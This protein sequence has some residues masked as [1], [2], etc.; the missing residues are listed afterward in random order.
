MRPAILATLLL[1]PALALAAPQTCDDARAIAFDAQGQALFEGKSLKDD[2]G[3]FALL[4]ADLQAG[5]VLDFY[6]SPPYTASLHFEWGKDCS[7]FPDPHS[8]NAW[9]HHPRY[10][11]TVRESGHYYFQIAPWN[12]PFED[13][14]QIRIEKH[15]PKCGDG[16]AEGL[17]LW[18]DG[19]TCALKTDESLGKSCN[20]PLVMRGDRLTLSF[21]SFSAQY[22]NNFHR[23]NNCVT[24]Y[25]NDD[26][27]E[28]WLDLPLEY[29]DSVSFWGMGT[30]DS[31]H[32]VEN[33]EVSDCMKS[34]YLHD[35][36]LDS[37]RFVSNMTGIGH[38]ILESKAKHSSLFE[39]ERRK[40][41]CG[42]G[43]VTGFEQC[44]TANAAS[45][46]GCDAECM[47]EPNAGES[48]ESAIPIKGDLTI[49]GDQSESKRA[50]W[51]AAELKKG[52]TL[53]I[54]TPYEISYYLPELRDGC[55]DGSKKLAFHRKIAEDEHRHL[56]M[57]IAAEDMT[58]YLNRRDDN[59]FKM[60]F[61]RHEP[62]CGDGLLEGIEECEDG[63][64]LSGDGCF[65]CKTEPGWFCARTQKG[66]ICQPATDGDGLTH[67]TAFI[68]SRDPLILE[69]EDFDADFKGRRTAGSRPNAYIEIALDRGEG[70]ELTLEGGLQAELYDIQSA[71][72]L[73][74]A[75]NKVE[76]YGSLIEGANRMR[77]RAHKA[78]SVRLRIW[79]NRKEPFYG[80][81]VERLAADPEFE[82]REARIA[83][84]FAE[85]GPEH[86]TLTFQGEDFAADFVSFEDSP[87]LLT[88]DVPNAHFEVPLKKGER[89]SARIDCKEEACPSPII[90]APQC[91][92]LEAVG[93]DTEHLPRGQ[94]HV[95]SAD[96]TVH[97]EF[98]YPIE[99][100]NRWQ[101]V[102]NDGS[103]DAELLSTPMMH[104]KYAIEIHRDR[105]PKGRPEEGQSP[106]KPIQVQ[107]D[108]NGEFTFSGQ[109]FASDFETPKKTPIRLDHQSPWMP[110]AWFEIELD[111]G[112]KLTAESN[113]GYSAL[114]QQR[115]PKKMHWIDDSY[116]PCDCRDPLGCFC[117][118]GEKEAL[119]YKAKK[120]EKLY[121]VISPKALCSW[122]GCSNDLFD[123][124]GTLKGKTIYDLKTLKEYAS[125]MCE[126]ERESFIAQYERCDQAS[127]QIQNQGPYRIRMKKT[128]E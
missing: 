56:S 55:G 86:R 53:A 46:L 31:V 36:P 87:C 30:Y 12:A 127:C 52:E 111:Q 64:Q 102:I 14:Y 28:F 18:D 48:C 50:S 113:L 120:K 75:A 105:A 44:E 77:Y 81:K 110:S 101:F 121:F 23:Q 93:Y 35:K 83:A 89:L 122:K 115:S 51:Y 90:S 61:H 47:L 71:K 73:A 63:N 38:F 49:R 22:E 67:E 104:P 124:Y 34:G 59:R 94:S 45:G 25:G 21:D 39:V 40:S 1:C 117:D 33:C 13:P 9:E 11:A 84:F 65:D 70:F 32:Q 10:R 7:T 2:F 29:G 109:D 43:E 57:F 85:E 106:K 126:G 3:D 92:F 24:D 112:E 78:E 5:E 15:L 8:K 123:P 119:V 60:A 128:K 6:V 108:Q 98:A 54:T 42:D 99:S 58:L 95:A 66:S 88:K 74:Y 20:Q 69:G 62:Q 97:L 107:F 125:D 103:D 27:F 118:E 17:E 80:I 19:Q 26:R 82:E 100:R 114:V 4:Q 41:I 116:A 68:L 72:K 79:Q 91:G 16:H 76:R 37:F 96:E